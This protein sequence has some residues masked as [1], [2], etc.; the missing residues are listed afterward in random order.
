ML[1]LE[2]NQTIKVA[3]PWVRFGISPFG[4]WRNASVDPVMGSKTTAGQTNYDDLFADVLLWS[5]EGWIDYMLPQLYWEVNH[6]AAGYRELI[7]WWSRYA[8]DRHMY[9]G[10]DVER[11][12]KA[13][14]LDEKMGLSRSLE[15]VQGNC[16]WYGYVVVDNHGGVAEALK[17]RYYSREA[18][19]PAYTH[20]DATPPPAVRNLHQHDNRIVWESVKSHDPMQEQRYYVVYR[21]D[22][23]AEDIDFGSANNIVAT[24]REHFVVVPTDNTYYY[25]VTAVDRCHNES[26]AV[27][28][29][30]N[31]SN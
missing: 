1:M 16:M 18:L 23:E 2:L 4:V 5:R 12:A 3:K 13:N 27:T 25:A 28:I 11:I 26:E 14:E 8:Y 30:I 29:F 6:K 7:N 19:I 24:T 22:P 20:L 10:E 15:N 9:I 21:C 17:D 31:Q